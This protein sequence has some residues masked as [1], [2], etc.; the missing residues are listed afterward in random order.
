MLFIPSAK[1]LVYL[2]SKYS[3]ISSLLFLIDF[4]TDKGIN[5]VQN[6][7]FSKKNGDRCLF[8]KSVK[9]LP[10]I[11]KEWVLLDS[12]YKEVKDKDGKL[13]YR[14]KSC[15]DKFPYTVDHE[16]RNVQVML[17]EKRLVTY[18]PSLAEKKRYEINRL[19]R[20]RKR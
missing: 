9:N 16:G 5:C 1:A 4:A 7:A 17:T 8:S 12:G 19:S 10:K 15:I 13:M 14:Y 3:N 18:N 6:I 2:F 20:K 11:E